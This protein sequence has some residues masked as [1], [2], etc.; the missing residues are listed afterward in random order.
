MKKYIIFGLIA[1]SF[2]L[3]AK[4]DECSWENN[5][6]YQFESCLVDLVK[7]R[8]SDLKIISAKVNA[9]V[10]GQEEFGIAPNLSEEF[11]QNT[12]QFDNY[13]ESFCNLYLK[14]VGAHMGGSSYIS[15][16]ECEAKVLNQRIELLRTITK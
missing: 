3:N 6:K 2:T 11:K 12:E 8:E 16:L 1:A 7:Q 10:V 15:T 5:T 13:R 4:A 9:V 14:A